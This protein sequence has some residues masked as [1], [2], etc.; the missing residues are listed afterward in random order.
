[1]E[2]AAGQCQP[3]PE[4]TA[5]PLPSMWDSVRPDRPTKALRRGEVGSVHVKEGGFVP[6]TSGKTA[7]GGGRALT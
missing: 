3:L 7:G 4:G 2:S 6:D 1:M 5:Q